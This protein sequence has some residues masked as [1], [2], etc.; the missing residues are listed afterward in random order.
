[1][2]NLGGLPKVV[3]RSNIFIPTTDIY[4]QV[5]DNDY[6]ILIF[7]VSGSYLWQTYDRIAK[8]K[9]GDFLFCHLFKI[10]LNKLAYAKILF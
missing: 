4:D 2:A 7:S 1:L 9:G 6:I 10:I 3:L 8:G 5:I